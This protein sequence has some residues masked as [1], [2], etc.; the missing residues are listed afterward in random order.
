MQDIDQEEISQDNISNKPGN[1]TITQETTNNPNIEKPIPDKKESSNKKYLVIIAIFLVL[2]FFVLIGYLV[3][4]VFLKE[5]NKGDGKTETSETTSQINSSS[6]ST[7]TTSIISATTSSEASDPYDGWLTYTN[8]L[9]G[10]NMKYPPSFTLDDANE[11]CVYFH[12]NVVRLN[13]GRGYMDDDF[14]CFRTGVGAYEIEYTPKNYSVDGNDYAIEEWYE[15]HEC[16]DSGYGN[17]Y[18]RLM[19][20]KILIIEGEDEVDFGL[21]YSGCPRDSFEAERDNVTKIIESVVW[22]K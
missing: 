18:G 17:V 8:D 22:G 20:G 2:I 3:Y 15:K 5:N 1:Q 6:S 7:S 12:K 19:L 9:L 11:E 13:I 4:F 10:Y 21:E 16:E 14:G